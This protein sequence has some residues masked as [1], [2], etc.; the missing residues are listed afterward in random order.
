MGVT[1]CVGFLSVSV[2]HEVKNDV[3]EAYVFQVTVNNIL[4]RCK[5]G[6][7]SREFRMCIVDQGVVNNSDECPLWGSDL[8]TKTYF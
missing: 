1:T 6:G 4:A 8:R 2:N 7:F 3:W 5:G